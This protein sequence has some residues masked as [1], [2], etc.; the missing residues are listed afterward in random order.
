MKLESNGCCGSWSTP[1]IAVLG[2]V[3]LG[4][5]PALSAPL[6][7]VDFGT[8]TPSP[9]ETGFQ[10]FGASTGGSTGPLTAT[11]TGLDTAQSSGSVALTLATGN[12]LAGTG[13]LTARDR[14]GNSTLVDQGSFTYAELYRDVINSNNSA[15]SLGLSGLN[16]NTTYTVKFFIYDDLATKTITFTDFTSGAAGTSGSVSFAAGYQF[17][18]STSNDQ[19]ATLLTVTSDIAGKLVFRS[20][21]S[22]SPAQIGGML[23]QVAPE[24]TSLG[25]SA[26]GLVALGR[27]RIKRQ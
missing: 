17:S 9:V 19:F 6:L 4:A 23:I 26:L 8:S 18:S 24:P 5:G 20:S 22:S 1:V 3:L 13:T 7:G 12:T 27:R 15:L 10:G 14:T 2:L 11:Y 25:L 16:P 21:T